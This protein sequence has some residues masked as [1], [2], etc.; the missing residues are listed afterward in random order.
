MGLLL[1]KSPE[2]RKIEVVVTEYPQEN[3]IALEFYSDGG[4]FGTHEALAGY[5][6]TS[7]RLLEI[8]QSDRNVFLET[9]IL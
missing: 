4:K 1:Y 5:I 9:E 7:A 2:E 3:K 8:L 6:L